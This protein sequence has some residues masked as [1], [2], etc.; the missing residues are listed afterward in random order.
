MTTP[1][2]SPNEAKFREYERYSVWMTALTGCTGASLW[3][4]D[5]MIDSAGAQGTIALRLLTWAAGFLPLAAEHG[6]QQRQPLAAA[7]FMT[8]LLWIL[9]FFPILMRLDGGQI[10]GIGGYMYF[11]MMGILLMQCFTYRTIVAYH[12]SAAA[13]PHLLAIAI[14]ESGFQH[15]HYACLIWP[16]TAMALI[17]QYGLAKQFAART[18]LKQQIEQTAI[19]DALTGAHNRHHFAAVASAEVALAQRKHL[20]LCALMVDIDHFKTIN[21]THGHAV[22]D[23][24]IQQVCATLKQN[25]RLTDML[26]RWGGEE[27]LILAADS[28]LEESVA[29]AERL[30]EK[31]ADLLPQEACHITVSIGVAELADR[32]LDELTQAADRALYAAKQNGRNQVIA[33]TGT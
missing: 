26:F 12:V 33:D 13:L 2:A 11:Q 9:L 3:I 10:Y 14:P 15:I 4:W 23:I 22:G 32:T 24:A 8:P 31:C 27:F 25:L 16:A 5:Y 28:N 7:L 20:P 19:T 6:S 17:A 21:D 29:L 18:A 1:S 30:R